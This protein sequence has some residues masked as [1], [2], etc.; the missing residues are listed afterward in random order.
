MHCKQHFVLS[1]IWGCFTWISTWKQVSLCVQLPLNKEV[2]YTS[3]KFNNGSKQICTHYIH[4]HAK[5]QVS[6][7][8]IT[9][10]GN[11]VKVNIIYLCTKRNG[12]SLSFCRGQI[13]HGITVLPVKDRHVHPGFIHIYNHKQFYTE[14]MHMGCMSELVCTHISLW[15]VHVSWH[16]HDHIPI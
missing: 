14:N 1:N 8:K 9:Y 6:P 3:E 7:L 10:F 5:T 2:K 11:S 15:G 4:V 12:Q 13:S 16:L